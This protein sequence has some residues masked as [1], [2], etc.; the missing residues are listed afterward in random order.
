MDFEKKN[1]NVIWF[2][3][4]YFIQRFQMILLFYDH[5]ENAMQSEWCIKP[6]DQF[7][8]TLK[9]IQYTRLRAKF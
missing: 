6:R 8:R 3:G 9:M 1:I 2:D 5:L 7:D 4:D